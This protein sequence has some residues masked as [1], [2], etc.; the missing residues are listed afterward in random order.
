MLI[1]IDDNLHDYNKYAEFIVKDSVRKSVSE[2]KLRKVR[3]S[4]LSCQGNFNQ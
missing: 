3:R 1:E 2:E 4:N